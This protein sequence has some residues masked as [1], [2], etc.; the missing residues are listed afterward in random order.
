MITKSE[1]RDGF[2]KGR[3]LIQEEWCNPA[4]KLWADEL[5]KEGVASAGPWEC[6]DTFQ[7]ERRR[8]TGV[9]EALHESRTEA[10]ADDQ[11]VRI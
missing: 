6:K 7:C 11:G 10:P 4:E 5:V 2:A 8:I 9:K 1:M 3:T